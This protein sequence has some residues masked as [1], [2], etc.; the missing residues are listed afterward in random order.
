LNEP[1]ASH[2]ELYEYFR[3]AREYQD[4]AITKEERARLDYY[5]GIYN[6]RL[7][8]K[9]LARINF[10]SSFRVWPHPDNPAQKML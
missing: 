3:L 9:E 6:L 5:Y 10:Q 8:N 4:Q 7:N 2:A 1:E